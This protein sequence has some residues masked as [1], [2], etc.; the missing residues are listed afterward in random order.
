MYICRNL[1][2]VLVSVI[3]LSA[4]Q[5]INT[6]PPP[7][8]K[9]SR[10]AGGSRPDLGPSSSGGSSSSGSQGESSEEEENCFPFKKAGGAL[11]VDN[12]AGIRIRS[13]NKVVLLGY[14]DTY[15][16]DALKEGEDSFSDMNFFR[17]YPKLI[18]IELDGL[19]L[20]PE[21]L[22]NLQKFAP[23]DLKSIIVRNCTAEKWEECA[24]LISDI[25][26]KHG[27]LG[28][29]TI[30]L[31]SLSGESCSK[32]LG[33]ASGIKFKFFNF[34][35]AEFSN[36]GIGHL[37]EILSASAET[38]L[39]LSLGVGK[40][41]DEEKEE[42]LYGHLAEAIGG[43]KSLRSLDLAF[44]SLMEVAL[45]HIVENIGHLIKLETLRLFFGGVH[46]HDHVK[47]FEHIEILQKSL[48]MLEKLGV[49]DISSNNFPEEA[50]QLI[51][52]A[53]KKMKNLN[54]LNISENLISDKTAAV[55]SDSVG[56]HGTL[57]TL[58]ANDCKINDAALTA[59][60]SKPE[61]TPALQ[62]LS[63]RNN[64]IKESIKSIPVASM[65]DLKVIDF[66]GNQI[67]YAEVIGMVDSVVEH[68]SLQV[69]NFKGNSG[70][71]STDSI[72]RSLRHDELE[73]KRVEKKIHVA[74][75]GV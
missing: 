19:A 41:I 67:G 59:L 65:T 24:D 4:I 11:A 45:A 8:S 21:M 3:L 69:V 29:L 32:I 71:E 16:S 14:D 73:K 28:S 34:V 43:L 51:L 72:E 30:V 70:I 60:F 44:M 10:P 54:V 48:E 22:E 40:I 18:S 55:L 27:N 23:Q 13:G 56:E 61:N 57:V 37:K 7:F 74:F 25:I 62:I 75:F 36:E 64:E 42:E 15:S 12:V 58:T 5:D 38:L 50:L 68:P 1:Y 39:G 66:S 46:E 26:R 2:K 35:A 63:L 9:P 33:A 31:P 53:L 6:A 20:T 47:L 17:K 52:I 49:L